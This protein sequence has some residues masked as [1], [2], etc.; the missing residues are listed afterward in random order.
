MTNLLDAN[1]LSVD[2]TFYVRALLDWVQQ[3]EIVDAMVQHGHA[4]RPDLQDL[5]L[6]LVANHKVLGVGNTYEYWQEFE[7][8]VNQTLH[9]FVS[10][11]KVRRLIAKRMEKLGCGTKAELMRQLE[12]MKAQLEPRDVA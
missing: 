12:D 9:A 1:G 7:A 4:T 2:L 3:D 6:S 8:K 10:N 5:Y 11:R